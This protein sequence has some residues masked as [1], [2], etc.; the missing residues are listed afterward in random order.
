MLLNYYLVKN[1]VFYS[2]Q[3]HLK[4][5]TKYVS[6]V[7]FSGLVSYFMIISMKESCPIPVVIAKVVAESIMFIFN[8]L[9]QRDFIFNDSEREPGCEK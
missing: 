1:M 2:K 6:L 5:F 4:V 8:F 9:V 7:V 3:A